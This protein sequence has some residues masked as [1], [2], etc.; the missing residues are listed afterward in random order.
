[1]GV[2]EADLDL[3]PGVVFPPHGGSRAVSKRA[4]KGSASKDRFGGLVWRVSDFFFILSDAL[5]SIP[6]KKHRVRPYGFHDN[7]ISY[8]L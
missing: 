8:F 6:L 1:M 7:F 3:T 4:R 2:A 5:R